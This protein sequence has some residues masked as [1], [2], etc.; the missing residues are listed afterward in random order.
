MFVRFV[1]KAIDARSGRR[2]GLFGAAT[3]LRDSGRLSADDDNRLEALWDW[4]NKNI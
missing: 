3:A 1:I 2:Q 4:F